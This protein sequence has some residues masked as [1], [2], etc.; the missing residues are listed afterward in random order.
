M[1]AIKYLLFAIFCFTLF[2]GCTTTTEVTFATIAVTENP[3]GTKIG[4][5]DRLQ[6][7]ILEAARNGGI[8]H[9][10]TVSVQNTNTYVTYLWPVLLM[11]PPMVINTK[12]LQE[13]IVTG[14]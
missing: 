9:I 14:E 1:K 2:L 6:G 8:Q 7:G 13:I 4:Q 11:M 5:V 10:S 3:I 12:N